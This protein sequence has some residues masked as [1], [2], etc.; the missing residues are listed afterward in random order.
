MWV[1]DAHIVSQNK[2]CSLYF[3]PFLDMCLA[4]DVGQGS[5]M[6]LSTFLMIGLTRNKPNKLPSK[7]RLSENAG[8]TTNSSL[9]EL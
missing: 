6:I 8:P 9:L 5:K 4:T 3:L 7:K 1:G 2:F